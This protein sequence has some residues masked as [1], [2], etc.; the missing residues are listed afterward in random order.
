[1]INELEYLKNLKF[2]RIENRNQYLVTQPHHHP[3]S[4]QYKDFKIREIKRCIYGLWGKESKGFRW[5]P[6]SAYYYANYVWIK[7]DNKK[8]EQVTLKPSFDDLEWLLFYMYTECYGFSG[9]ELDEE[10]SCDN[11]LIDE[12]DMEMAKENPER[13]ESLLRPNG[14]YKKYKKCQEYLKE[15]KEKEL[16]RPLWNNDA[17]DAIILGS[18]G[19]G[20]SY[21]LIGLTLWFMCLD[22]AKAFS[23]E[24]AE[25]RISANVIMG[26]ADD[27]SKQNFLTGLEEGMNYLLTEPDLGVYKYKTK[28]LEDVS[29]L[30][31]YML[32]KP[33]NFWRYRYIENGLESG[34]TGSSFTQVAYSPNKKGGGATAA[35][36]KRVHLSIVD[37]VGKLLVSA[38]AIWGSNR[39]LTRRT[40]K[41]GSQ[42]F[43]GT[44]G[45]MDLIQEAK[46]MFQNPKDFEMVAFENIYETTSNDIGFFIPAFLAKRQFKDKDGNT[47]M[48]EAINFFIRERN[49]CVTSEKLNEE[50][51]NYPLVPEDMW[52]T[53]ESSI[54]PREEAKAVKRRLL[55]NNLY[56]K[57]RSFVKLYWD[58]TKVN[59][60]GYNIIQEKDAIKID[61][62]RETQGKN[63]NKNKGNKSTQCDIIIYEFPEANA[64]R[65]LYKFAGIDPY[66]AEDVKEGESLGSFFLL[67]NPK[68]LSEGFSGDIIVAEITGKYDGRAAFNELIEKVMAL[69]GNPSRSLMFESDRGDDLK[70]YFMKRNKENLLALTPVKYEDNKAIIKQRLSYGFSHGNQL[71]KLHNLTQLK[72]WLMDITTIDGVEMKNIERITSLGLLDE[73]IEYDWDLDKDK[74]ANYDRI[75]AFMGCLIAR[76]ENYNR[77]I[78]DEEVKSKVGSL[79]GFANK[80]IV[81]KLKNKIK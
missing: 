70:E 10:Y 49:N 22:G 40:R 4:R 47:R 74:K 5:M 33:N 12:F 64:P 79:A 68:Y 28:G 30:G 67:K 37:E 51:M 57:K 43:A 81:S 45:N 65:D 23:K 80:G 46:K 76:R 18:R 13:Y 62:F 7:Q 27:T 60:I 50:K 66:V 3:A 69:Y 29:L 73:I 31:R 78:R 58:S 53:K 21:T 77:L 52:I 20:K 59:G 56:K 19:A 44:S 34:G 2:L 1:M 16:G 72:E 36:S 17:K 54:L 71:G 35:A 61:S 75:S 41:F 14:E 32:G 15:L 26:S 48:E 38:I 63:E 39:A 25:M 6:P 55:E 11:A 8:N 9:F 24:F 42:I